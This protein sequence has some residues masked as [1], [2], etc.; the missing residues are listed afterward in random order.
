M[1][2]ADALISPAVGCTFGMISLGLM[3]YACKQLR[4]KQEKND[5]IIPLMGIMGAF[6]FAAQ[7]INFT[8][9][10][11]GSSGHLGG[12]MMLAILL[13]PH[14]AFIAMASILTIQALFFADGGILALGCNIFNLA[15]YSSYLAFPYIYKGIVKNSQSAGKNMFAAIISSILVLQLG[16]LSVV[17]QTVLSGKTELPFGT[18]LLFMLPI[19]L[20]I[21]L[22][23]GI[24]TALV[25]S[26]LGKRQ[27]EILAITREE[28]SF[29]RKINQA[30]IVSLV[31]AT[32]A[33]GGILSW[34]AS[35][36]PDGLEWSL[37]KT[38]GKEEIEASHSGIHDFF[39]RIQEKVSIL[40]DYGFKQPEP[41]STT[42]ELAPN[43]PSVDGA[44]STSGLLGGL[45]TFFIIVTITTL[46]ILKKRQ[47]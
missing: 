29:K 42:T 31:L 17:I 26:Y 21:G 28:V 47:T 30:I 6:V 10:G 14:A 37:F 25:I 22:V 38:M 36:H 34:F 16:A 24:I 39:H 40:P 32:L 27:P 13:G 20:A 9:P 3:G 1:H 46:V 7:M 5:K 23:E 2:M 12:G 18:F 44:T 35:N 15:F 43:W 33:I 11:T 4:K 45:I 19:H 8:I 41:Q